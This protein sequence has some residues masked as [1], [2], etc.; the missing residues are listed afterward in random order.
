MNHEF[1]DPGPKQKASDKDI[2]WATR[3]TD[4][5]LL[6]CN[7]EGEVVHINPTVK[8]VLRGINQSELLPFEHNEIVRS[9]V[10]SSK[11]RKIQSELGDETFTWNYHFV[12]DR[13][14]VYVIG[15]NITLELKHEYD[16]LH[17]PLT[18]LP[19]RRSFELALNVAVKQREKDSSYRYALVYIDIDY[20]KTIN[21]Q[22]GHEIGDFILAE[23]GKR[24]HDALRPDDT[25]ARIGG[26]EFGV[27]LAWLRPG[28]LEALTAQVEGVLEKLQEVTRLPMTFDDTVVF[29][30]ASFGA[31]VAN[32]RE[33]E[34]EL[35]RRAD[36]ALYEAKLAGRDC[37]RFAQ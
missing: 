3:L 17:D 19:N 24:L 12:P 36:M 33:T 11:T 26:E 21:D 31:T 27:I 4:Q 18:G 37:I 29:V 6:I 25:V 5:F 35:R 28:T 13:E 15:N 32:V 34:R 22:H 7:I 8:K 30:T 14:L 1:D 16:A 9:V 2:A 23:L 10:S 20:F